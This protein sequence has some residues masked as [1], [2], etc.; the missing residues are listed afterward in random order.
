MRVSFSRDGKQIVTAGDDTTA[1][2]WDVQTA[3][4]LQRFTVP[5][6][7]M[8]AAEFSSDGRLVLTAGDD[9]VARLWDVATG[10]E[11]RRFTGHSDQVKAAVFSPDGKYILTASLDKTARRW[12][13]DYHD[14]IR[15]LCAELT[16]DLTPEERSQYGITN[17]EPTCSAP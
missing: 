6:A 14:T 7:G 9:G 5:N 11:V 12:P 3:Q 17:P 4:E 8:K 10:Q 16:R 1:R 13:I 15:A 2:G